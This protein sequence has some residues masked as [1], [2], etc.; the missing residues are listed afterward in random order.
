MK[1]LIVVVILVP[2]LF[3]SS[4][5]WS[6][7]SVTISDRI[8]LLKC[9]R[10]TSGFKQFCKL[11]LEELKVA[12]KIQKKFSFEN[13]DF[14]LES[15]FGNR[16]ITLLSLSGLVPKIK[17]TLDWSNS[18]NCWKDQFRND[19]MSLFS[20]R[21]LVGR[22]FAGSNNYSFPLVLDE[23]TNLYSNSSVDDK[24]LALSFVFNFLD[25][26]DASGAGDMGSKRIPLACTMTASNI[27]IEY[28]ELL[29]NRDLDV[30]SVD[31]GRLKDLILKSAVLHG[32]YV[33]R[34]KGALCSIYH[35][36]DTLKLAEGLPADSKLDD[37][38]LNS[39]KAVESLIAHALTIG[40][41]AQ[42]EIPR[43]EVPGNH[44][45]VLDYEGFFRQKENLLAQECENN[46]NYAVSTTPFVHQEEIINQQGYQNA[47]EYLAAQ[48][49][50]KEEISAA[51]ALI[52]VSQNSVENKRK[53]N[54]IF[55]YAKYVF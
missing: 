19:K 24:F 42:E 16:G 36:V 44:A 53:Y 1:A 2:V 7:K 31:A 39:V 14:D 33:D 8:E 29:I 18:D 41:I 6:Q 49:Q 47:K 23:G 3:L 22:V 12:L 11:D 30:L 28:D 55:D 34:N 20:N 27:R 10:I 45:P 52:A 4:N 15:I 54:W 26:S 21:H 37:L 32:L 46:A 13:H 50:L 43:R 38:S 51:L 5:V 25:A 48:T 17:F 35:M 9:K 40:A